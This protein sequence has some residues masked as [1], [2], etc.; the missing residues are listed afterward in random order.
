M[1][2]SSTDNSAPYHFDFSG[3]LAHNHQS[4]QDMGVNLNQWF[5]IM[6]IL[7]V[8]QNG[9]VSFYEVFEKEIGGTDFLR[10][11][12]AVYCRPN[13]LGRASDVWPLQVLADNYI[14]FSDAPFPNGF[15]PPLATIE[16]VP[17]SDP[18]YLINQDF[19]AHL[20]S[21]SPSG[22]PSWDSDSY[23]ALHASHDSDYHYPGSISTSTR[24]QM[25]LSDILVKQFPVTSPINPMTVVHQALVW[26]GV[27]TAI[28]RDHRMN[29]YRS[30]K[31]T[32][33]G[34]PML[35]TRCLFLGCFWVG[36]ENPFEYS[37]ELACKIITNSL[38][39]AADLDETTLQELIAQPFVIKTPTGSVSVEWDTLHLTVSQATCSMSKMR[40]PTT[41]LAFFAQLMWTWKSYSQACFILWWAWQKTMTAEELRTSSPR[42]F[43]ISKAY[44]KGQKL[45]RAYAI[46]MAV[47]TDMYNNQDLYPG[48]R[49]AVRALPFISIKNVFPMH[50]KDLT[51][52][53]YPELGSPKFRIHILAFS[54]SSARGG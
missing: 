33:W 52:K 4:A 9:N 46:I 12:E 27:D 48:F 24:E 49:D 29:I 42:K 26:K 32:N 36:L 23:D 53:V 40:G 19:V 43:E 3:N 15:P 1:V 5:G 37:E 6:G 25:I 47:L 10:T 50:L 30:L 17:L 21:I 11:V 41:F 54:K 8:P 51:P 14:Q 2:T 20:S 44:A 22:G 34:R 45:S 28:D 39:M 35:L 7:A 16:A 31:R 38:L 18:S 13:S